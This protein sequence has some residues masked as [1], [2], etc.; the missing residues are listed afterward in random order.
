MRQY[1]P[2]VGPIGV[3]TT[4]PAITGLPWLAVLPWP[5]VRIPFAGVAAAPSTWLQMLVPTPTPVVGLAWLFDNP[6]ARPPQRATLIPDVTAPIQL[7]PAPPAGGSQ[8]DER[9]RWDWHRSFTTS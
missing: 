1:T 9:R 3:T 8:R 7:V 6:S 2:V 5:P 4:P